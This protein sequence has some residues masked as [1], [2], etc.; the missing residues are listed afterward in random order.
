MNGESRKGLWL[1]SLGL[2]LAVVAIYWIGLTNG[3]VF[4]DERLRDGTVFG[5]YGHLTE[6]KAR[7]ISYGSFVWVQS[8]VG[9]GWWKQRV[10]NIALHLC[11]VMAIYRLLHLLLERTEFPANDRTAAHFEASRTLA[12]RIGVALFALNPVAVYAVAYLIQRSILMAAMF[13]AVGCATFVQGLVTRRRLWIGLS[14]VCYLLAV[15][16][17][18]HAVTAIA[19][20][21]PLYVFVQ[22]PSL[23]KVAAV[24]GAAVLLL[25]VTAA[26]LYRH[27]GALIGA[28]FDDTSRAYVLELER[29]SPGVSGQLYL[30]SIVNQATRFFHYGL[31]WFIPDVTRMSIDI[32][33]EFPLS[34]W[35]WPH[36]AAALGYVAVLG[37]SAWLLSR[38]SGAVGL[39]GLCIH[40]PALL[41]V[42]EFATVWVQDPFVLYRSYLWALT[43]PALVALLLVGLKPNILL[44]LGAILV[45]LFA[46]LTFER[47]LSLRDA[48]AAWADAAAKIDMTA[49]RNAVGRWRPLLN[50]GAEYLDKGSN[51]TAY[52][53]FSQAAALG[54]P[55][56]SAHF[57]A[58]VSLQQMNQHRRALDEFDKAEA[59]G[60][61]DAA[62]DYHRGESHYAMGRF[63]EAFASFGAALARPQDILAEQHTRLRRAEAAIAINNSDTAI[64]DYGLL[65]ERQPDNARYLVGLSM[66]YIGKRDFA[67]ATAILDPLISK[68]PS[69]PA[70]FAR[71]LA[72]YL[73]GDAAAS[74]E[75]LERALRD[76]PGNPQYRALLKRL[77]A[78]RGAGTVKLPK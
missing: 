15:L 67:A 72:R 4:D 45:C 27:F 64:A 5:S 63:A 43:M 49:G 62:L 10:V 70:Y 75:D 38:R 14:V 78:E 55:R 36:T 41:F 53:L 34:W 65:V 31:L 21:V 6:L 16:S 24:T 48:R 57:N 76:E 12:L 58:G 54:E 71:A 37:G 3:L 60:F 25:L 33:P 2:S 50:L 44:A 56:G 42:T 47:L 8:L 23:R 59:Q 51:E 22:R 61:T 19:L 11:T 20:A 13:V 1:F 18:E 26:P 46:A 29:L 28:A 69:S 35:G 66:A 32:R 77:D 17:K 40:I 7:L 30:L 52:R 39:A 9:E 74:R 68:A 73:S